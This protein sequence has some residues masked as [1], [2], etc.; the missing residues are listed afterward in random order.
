[1]NDQSYEENQI[2]EKP[3]ESGK[4]MLPIS[5]LIA[6]V[7]IAGAVVYSTGK[8]SLESQSA[9]NGNAAVAQ[10]PTLGSGSMENIKSI[11]NDDHILG[12]PNAPVKLVEFSDTECPFCKRFHPTMQQIIQEYGTKGQVAWVYRHFPLDQIH[13]KARKEAEATECANELG[14][15]QKFWAYLDR[16]FEVTPSNNNLDP[17]ELPRIAEYVGLD[18]AKFNTCLNSGK[19][20]QH[21]QEDLDDAMRSGGTGTP[22]NIVIAANGKKFDITGAQPYSAVKSIIDIALQEK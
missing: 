11:S 15:D 18:V 7:M 20:A 21:I 16:L 22:Y 2:M 9:Q 17:A 3:R 12:N 10:Q 8:R 5:I 1:M 19:Y 14:G 4:W 13:S 6:G